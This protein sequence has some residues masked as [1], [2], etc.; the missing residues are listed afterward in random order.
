MDNTY[1]IT[2]TFRTIFSNITPGYA[3]SLSSVADTTDATLAVIRSL[4]MTTVSEPDLF[5]I[6]NTVRYPWEPM[7]TGLWSS[8]WSSVRANGV[9]VP[10]TYG[11]GTVSARVFAALAKR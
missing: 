9:T 7:T 3:T 10:D 2:K 5:A 1:A 6:V 11:K 4:G 8:V